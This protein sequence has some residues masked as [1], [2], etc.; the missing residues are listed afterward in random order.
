MDPRLVKS[1]VNPAVHPYSVKQDCFQDFPHFKRT[2]QHF[3]AGSNDTTLMS[4]IY[5]AST[6]G[7]KMTITSS[8]KCEFQ[9]TALDHRVHVANGCVQ[10]ATGP[11]AK[12]TAI[13]LASG[14]LWETYVGMVDS[15]SP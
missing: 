4:K 8:T 11:L 1:N 5:Q 13:R 12:V 9:K 15:K 10:T 2:P 6:A 7:P 14:K 3:A